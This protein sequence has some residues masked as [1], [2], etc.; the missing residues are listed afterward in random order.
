MPV[1]DLL[2]FLLI[3]SLFATTARWQTGTLKMHNAY[4][5]SNRHAGLGALVATLVMTELNTSTLIAFSSAGFFA[6]DWALV[7]T[8][9]FLV[10]LAFY[11]LTV[12]KKYRELNMLSVSEVF[13]RKY[14]PT[15]ARLVNICLITAM[16]LFSGTYVRSFT[17]FFAPLL[18]INMWL[19]SLIMIAA[20]LTFTLRRGLV[21]IVR[22]DMLAFLVALIFLPLIFYWTLNFNESIPVK[23]LSFAAGRKALSPSFILSLIIL[24]AFSYLI[25]PWY[26]QKIFSA[27]NAKIAYW[28]VAISS[29]FVFAFYG[30]IVLASSALQQKGIELKSPENALPFILSNIVPI[31]AR[32][33]G[34]GLIFCIAATTL[35]GIWNA[36][37]KVILSD[38]LM[39]RNIN[40]KRQNIIIYLIAITSYLV[41][42][43]FVNNIFTMIILANI[44]IFAL[45]FAL[46]AA[47]YWPLVTTF[48]AYG[49]TLIGLSWGIFCYYYFGEENNYM[50]YWIF[51]G[52]P[53]VFG[54]GIILSLSTTKVSTQ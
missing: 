9:V 5:A 21:S 18:R 1:F 16:M 17:L 44:P 20:V 35:A 29:V 27:R 49:S 15:Y 31:G 7:L 34:Y 14:G 26:S 42:N 23:A 10:G 22:S 39:P 43:I 25:A 50:T 41:A 4:T 53:F 52:L 36:A 32:G 2:G 28:S 8:F 30:C 38:L 45:S 11:A 33:I 54:S 48:G 12:T 3:I 37:A 47:F 40:S 46:L 19:L 13:L 6:G 24:T 51:L